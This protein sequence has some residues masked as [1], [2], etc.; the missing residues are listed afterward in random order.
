[1]SFSI[2]KR[3]RVPVLRIWGRLPAQVTAQAEMAP[4]ANRS[5][6]IRSDFILGSRFSINRP[7]RTKMPAFENKKPKKTTM[8]TGLWEQETEEEE[9]HD[10]EDWVSDSHSE[11]EWRVPGLRI[12]IL[13]ELF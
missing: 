10:Y 2:Y 1:M 4:R 5:A 9:D 6:A 13:L 11:E 3:C 7:R 8:T 12:W